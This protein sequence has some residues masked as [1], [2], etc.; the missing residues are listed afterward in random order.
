MKTL[1]LVAMLSALSLAVASCTSA[2]RA[3]EAAGPVLPD[4]LGVNIHFTDP[5]AGEMKMLADGGFRWVRM[6]FGWDGT[7][8]QIGRYDFSAYDRLM[9]ALEG[10]K[11]RA[12][13][14]LD[15]SNRHYDGGLSPHSEEG[16][17]AFAAWAAAAATHF[18]GRGILWEMYNEPNIGFWKP[19]PNPRDYVA[20]ALEVGKAL[21]AAAPGETYI[22]PATSGVDLA[23]L[24][25]C[26]KAG[27]LEYW[28]A[29]SVHPYRQEPPET[30]AADYARLRR[31][32]ARYA[33]KGK[34]IPIYSGEW[35][36]SSIWQ[37]FDA[38]KQGRY[39]PRQWLTNLANDV[40]LSIWYDWHDDGTD[41]KEPEH[42]FG[43]IL[44]PHQ[45]GRDPCYD[46]KPA[47]LAARTLTSVLAGFRFHKRLLGP[48]MESPKDRVLLFAKGDE[49]RL[50]AWTEDGPSHAAVIPASPG[51]FRVTS[52]TGEALPPIEADAKGLSIVLT[53]APQYLVPEVPNDLLRVAAAWQRAPLEIRGPG[54]G[55]RS[56][57]LALRNP[58]D[59]PIQVKAETAA[60]PVEVRPGETVSLVSTY[61]ALRDGEPSTQYLRCVVSGMGTVEQTTE[62]V[63][64]NPLHIMVLPP[65]GKDLLVQIRNPAGE[66]FRGDVVLPET[67]ADQRGRARARVEFKAGECEKT[68]RVPLGKPV[69]RTRYR[70]GVR[71]EDTKGNVQ[72]GTGLR[73]YNLVDDF[74]GH[75]A[76]TLAEAWQVVPD[77]DAKVASTQTVALAAPPEGPPAP[78]VKTLR[79]AYAFEA[80]W[81]FARLV[82]RTDALRKIQG[83]PEACGL[84]VY[85]DGTGNVLRLRFVDATGQTFQPNG[86]A[87]TWKGWRYVEMPMDGSR[88]GHWGGTGDGVVHDPIRWDTLILVDSAGRRK[89]E[90]AVY[91]AWPTLIRQAEW[92]GPV[93]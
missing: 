66:A 33:P 79:I 82:P 41:P 74:A 61:P 35:G 42:H 17:R 8:R 64:T 65:A 46:P 70:L 84:W 36:Y 31:L 28:S 26:F 93:P 90:G 16:R 2:V 29:V 3:V 24:E 19:Q 20:L 15:Y 11:M 59:R 58:L 54:G 68:V 25:E 43:T 85:G 5:Q 88:A 48:S 22:G 21:R 57:A 76:D 4:G 23:F 9:A 56:L 63:A 6:D 37:N 40:P 34:A 73:D 44:H 67:P 50:A 89:T 77:G 27:L 62:F 52:H 49:V 92:E 13:L 75:T 69:G 47:Y 86:E 81:K 91:I 71:I 51:R 38:E 14:I 32:I 30:A 55:T 1:V 83:R 60:A 10:Q 7:E 45:A 72:C 12:L 39:L 87:L 53:D 18:Q 78:G 80:G